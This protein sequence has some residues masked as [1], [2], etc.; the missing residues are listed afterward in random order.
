MNLL[1]FLKNAR[2]LAELKGSPGGKALNYIACF[3]LVSMAFYIALAY[4]LSRID[5]I[6]ANGTTFSLL[7]F[8]VFKYGTIIIYYLFRWN[9]CFFVS[10]YLPTRKRHSSQQ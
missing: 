9:N 8:V 5:I 6:P 1:M 7:T 2:V 10:L 4:R 3:F